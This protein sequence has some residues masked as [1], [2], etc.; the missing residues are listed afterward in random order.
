MFFSVK[1]SRCTFLFIIAAT[2]IGGGLSDQHLYKRMTAERCLT[3]C[4]G[5]CSSPSTADSALLPK[6]PLAADVVVGTERLATN[7]FVVRFFVEQVVI[8]GPPL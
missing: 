4:N 3:A 7:V 2:L 8:S 5:G 1:F 6:T